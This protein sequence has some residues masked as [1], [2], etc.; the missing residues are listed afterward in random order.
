MAA[1]NQSTHAKPLRSVLHPALV[2]LPIALL[3]LSVLLDVASWIFPQRDLFLVRGAFFCLLAGI[4]SGLFAALFG[5]LDYLGIRNDH[6]AKKTATLHMI[7]NV[8]ALGLF[9]VSVGLRYGVLD[10]ER[11]APVPLVISLVAFAVLGYSGYLGGILV[12]DDGIGVGRHRRRTRTPETTI[13]A[14]TPKGSV[15]V[16]NED[17]LRDGETLRVEVNG[18]IVV[19]AKI[20][21]GYHAF[22]EFCTHRYGPLSEGTLH[23]CEIMCPW[24]RSRFDVRNGRVTSGPAKVDL[25]TFRAEARDGKIWVEAPDEKK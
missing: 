15:A 10:A 13:S 1:S 8:V 24:H 25:R 6:P 2:H 23:G 9:A 17:A 18:T 4:G 3:P 11:T 20:A 16:A 14:K 5:V 7:L 19:I 12:Y 22:Q 21:G